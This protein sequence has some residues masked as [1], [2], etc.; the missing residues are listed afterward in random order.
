MGNCGGCGGHGRAPGCEP[1]AN[2]G[3]HHKDHA[4]DQIGG[5]GRAGRRRGSGQ[6][7][8]ADV[9]SRGSSAIKRSAADVLAP[10]AP[11]PAGRTEIN[12]TNCCVASSCGNRVSLAASCQGSIASR[13]SADSTLSSM[14]L[15]SSPNW[16]KQEF[17]VLRPERRPHDRA[18][19]FEHRFA[20]RVSPLLVRPLRSARIRRW[21]L[22]RRPVSR[23]SGTA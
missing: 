4:N 16:C 9:A 23:P 15:L 3:A 17:I 12:E 8:A 10:C 11:G 18:R 7:R 2:K 5:G 22:V 14:P 6:A 1:L 13:A 20:T 19:Q 21:P